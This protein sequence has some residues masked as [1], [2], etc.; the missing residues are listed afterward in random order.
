VVVIENDDDPQCEDI[1]SRTLGAIDHVYVVEPTPGIARARNA[2]L[3][4]AKSKHPDWIAFLDDDQIADRDWLVNATDILK[5]ESADVLFPIVLY[6]DNE[7]PS[8]T[9][10]HPIRRVKTGATNGVVFRASI[11]ENFKFDEA[12]M[13]QEDGD[14]FARVR[15]AGHTL[16]T[17]GNAIVYEEKHASRDALG[18]RLEHGISK[19]CAA[20]QRDPKRIIGYIALRIV[21]A[22]Y[23]LIGFP[24]VYM[25][26]K[27]HALDT[28]NEGIHNLGA[29][30][31]ACMGILG[32]K[33]S[34]YSKIDGA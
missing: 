5:R 23:Q 18:R 32:I 21:K 10:A 33:Y 8:P 6:F 4:A 3:E 20:I 24:F 28:R 26:S 15:A 2:A 27:K 16:I 14:L 29:C 7:L 31:G 25:F 9:T 13:C 12:L 22:I 30:I 19:G 34:F 1:V 11:A 17:G